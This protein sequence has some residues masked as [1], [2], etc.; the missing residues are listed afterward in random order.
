MADSIS[1]HSNNKNSTINQLN[2]KI[3][4][5]T[6]EEFKCDICNL[7]LISK[8]QLTIHLAGK[9]HLKRAQAN[10]SDKSDPNTK[11]TES[12]INK[13]FFLFKICRSNLLDKRI[14][15]VKPINNRL[16]SFEIILIYRFC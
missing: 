13:L 7:S 4:D 3:D 12:K 1:N 5:K 6:F 2:T 10:C 8:D 9:K 11:K 16:K 14:E 15:F